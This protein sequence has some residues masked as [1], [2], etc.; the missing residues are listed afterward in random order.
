MI[1]TERNNSP[2]LI[3][4]KS[5]SKGRKKSKRQKSPKLEKSPSMMSVQQMSNISIANSSRHGMH[6]S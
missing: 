5:T 2:L 3:S 4:P 6:R 1:G